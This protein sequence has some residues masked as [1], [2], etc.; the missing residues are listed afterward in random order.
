MNVATAAAPASIDVVS[1]FCYSA[2]CRGVDRVWKRALPTS[3]V[4]ACS[5]CD[6]TREF[7]SDQPGSA[8]G[9]GSSSTPAPAAA[10]APATIS[11]TV[12][13]TRKERT[14]PDETKFKRSPLQSAIVEAVKEQL[15]AIRAEIDDLKK[16][17]R[18]I[19]KGDGDRD[20]ERKLDEKLEREIPELVTRAVV[21]MLATPAGAVPARSKR[22]AASSS[23]EDDAGDG[24]CGHKNNLKKCA[25][26]RAK[27]AAAA[28]E[29]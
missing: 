25:G 20:L 17:I 7:S 29:S 14:M 11:Q 6:R 9:G 8:A 5:S 4:Y 23:A 19:G 22:A 21:Q 2:A 12:K 13:S 16:D 3:S 1:A 26:C 27:R 28:T 18:E 10:A 15:V 24:D